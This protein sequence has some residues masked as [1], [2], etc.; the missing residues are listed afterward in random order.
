MLRNRF[1]TSFAEGAVLAGTCALVLSLPRLADACGATPSELRETVPADG[2]TYPAN[3]ALMFWGDGLSVDKVTVT[4]DGEPAALVPAPLVEGLGA[5]AVKVEPEPLPG[6]VVVVAGEFCDEN[7]N[8]P[9][10]ITFTAGE[11]D[12]TVPAPVV[13]ASF[14]AV[15]EH[16]PLI[17]PGGCD[18]GFQVDQTIYVHLEQPAP[19]AGEAAS[20]FE[21]TWDPG[22][23]FEPSALR[24]TARALEPT[25][26]LPIALPADRF[27][28]ADVSTDVCFEVV[29]RDAAGNAS[30]PFELCPPCFMRADAAPLPDSSEAPPEPLWTEAD[31]VPGSACAP[32]TETTGEDTAGESGEEPTSGGESESGEAPTSGTTAEPDSETGAQEETSDSATAGEDAPDKGCACNSDGEGGLGSLLLLALGLV[33]V[34]RRR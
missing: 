4:I 22:E 13:E 16:A 33:G 20:F 30:A 9:A 5:L 1:W 26:I 31:A 18:G 25:T 3:A 7:D 15:F 21:V 19:T 11:P 8:C 14:F 12:V 2:D 29:A 27:G 32:A 23:E 17:L 10:S 6:Q 34:R 24:R 28:G